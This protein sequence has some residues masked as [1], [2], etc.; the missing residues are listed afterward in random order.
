MS[1]SK[2][3]ERN[4]N[5]VRLFGEMKSTRLV[6]DTLGIPI[7]TVGFVL[8]KRGI[9]TPKAG[10]RHNP[11]T[12]CDRNK[13]KVLQ[14]FAEGCSLTQMAKAVGTKCLEVKKFL[15]RQGIE[16][17][18]STASYGERHYAWKG[19]LVN[20]DGYVEIHVKG[21]PYARKHTHYILEHR[22]VMEA[23]IGRYLLPGE[24]VHHINGVKDDN[25][26]ENLQLFQTNG[27][28]LAVDLK[29]KC[30][31]WSE[32]GK[33]R[34]LEGNRRRKGRK[35]SHSQSESKPDDQECS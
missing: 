2:N 31:K 17:E 9:P 14:M 28:H 34:I 21:H 33:A 27:E 16:K 29:G 30:P 18:W 20:K 26:I 12:A 8:R 32:D 35:R 19:R 11:Y 3:I 5:I 25:R 10:R 7:A 1:W 15:A 4:D 23:H 6:A 24:V 22:L 13:D